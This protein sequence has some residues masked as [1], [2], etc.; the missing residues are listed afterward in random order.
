MSAERATC[1][2][3]TSASPAQRSREVIHSGITARVPSGERE[4]KIRSRVRATTL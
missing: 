1:G 3:S 2:V 4:K